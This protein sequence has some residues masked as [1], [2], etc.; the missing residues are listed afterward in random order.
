[1]VTTNSY[2][3]KKQRTSMLFTQKNLERTGVKFKKRKKTG[4]RVTKELQV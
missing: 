4:I 1:M 3:N 2:R